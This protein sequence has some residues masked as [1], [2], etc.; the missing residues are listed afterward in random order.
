M[1]RYDELPGKIHC[2]ATISIGETRL[3]ARFVQR[4]DTAQL[5]VVDNAATE[6]SL[7]KT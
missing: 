5:P 1:R 3:A 4:G 7:E 6:F 2:A